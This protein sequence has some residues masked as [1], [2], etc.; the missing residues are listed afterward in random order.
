MSIPV[1]MSMLGLGYLTG[2]VFHRKNKEIKGIAA[3]QMTAVV[4]LLTIMGA[5]IGADE[6]VMASLGSIG[7]SSV[8]LTMFVFAGSIMAVTV[9][10]KLLGLNR[11]G[12]RK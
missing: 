7:L 6:E 3:A 1:L 8:V 10:R 9:F 5:R 4:I 12:D 2:Y 11:E